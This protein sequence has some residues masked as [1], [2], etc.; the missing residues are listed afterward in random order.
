MTEGMSL[1]LEIDVVV[2]LEDDEIRNYQCSFVLADPPL[3]PRQ[4]SVEVPREHQ[5]IHPRVEIHNL[6]PP[7]IPRRIPRITKP[8]PPTPKKDFYHKNICRNIIRK[9]IRS[10]Q[11]EIYL[12]HVLP[13]CSNN[14]TVYSQLLT[15]MSF[16]L[17]KITGPRALQMYLGSECRIKGV[18]RGYLKWYLKEMYVRNALLEGEMRDLKKYIR[19]K[20]DVLLPMISKL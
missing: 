3:L 5:L 19:Y 14:L 17:E 11:S 9:A 4:N 1:D 13:L 6:P 18:W 15:T 10:L 2:D 16:H 20:N 12:P 7:R 8:R